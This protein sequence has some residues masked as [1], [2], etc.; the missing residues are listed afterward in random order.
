MTPGFHTR[1][2]RRMEDTPP[3][4]IFCLRHRAKVSEGAATNP[5]YPYYLVYV[6]EEWK[7][8]FWASPAKANA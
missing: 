6:S 7:R 8:G 1:V 2:R 3:G 5:L 4:I